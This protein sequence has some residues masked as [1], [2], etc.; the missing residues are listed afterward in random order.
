MFICATHGA[1]AGEVCLS[2]HRAYTA[3]V[4]P[5]HAR[6]WWAHRPND[7][8]SFYRM[9]RFNDL[10]SAPPVYPSATTDEEPTPGE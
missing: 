1:F 4:W 2:C 6:Y 10:P 8:E 9:E 3:K 5:V 7:I